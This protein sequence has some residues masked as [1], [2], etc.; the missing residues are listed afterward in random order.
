M[1]DNH[2]TLCTMENVFIRRSQDQGL[3]R[4]L[5]KPHKVTDP[6]IALREDAALPSH[7]YIIQMQ[8]APQTTWFYVFLKVEGWASF[9]KIASAKDERTTLTD[10]NQSIK[11]RGESSARFNFA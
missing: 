1:H 8:T 3:T 4:H 7:K 9:S 2:I 5:E 11:S 10:F 6:I